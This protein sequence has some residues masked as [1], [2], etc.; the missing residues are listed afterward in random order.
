MK[1]RDRNVWRSIVGAWPD[2]AVAR[3]KKKKKI[4]AFAW[5]D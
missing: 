2:K 4:P 5:R 1:A 3:M